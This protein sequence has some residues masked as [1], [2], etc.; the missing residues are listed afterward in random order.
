MFTARALPRRHPEPTESAAPLIRSAARRYTRADVR[1]SARRIHE[2]VDGVS[3]ATA[4]QLLRFLRRS[5]RALLC[6]SRQRYSC[7]ASS[8]ESAA[9]LIATAVQLLRFLRRSTRALLCS[10]AQP[11]SSEASMESR[12]RQWYSCSASDVRRE[13]CSVHTLSRS[14]DTRKRRA[15]QLL[16]FRRAID[17]AVRLLET[18]DAVARGEV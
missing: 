4:V 11:L 5:T 12:A 8:D 15:V 17:T 10:S 9:L 2:S 14:S 18:D 7:F 16:R 1:S 13:R 3:R 6:S